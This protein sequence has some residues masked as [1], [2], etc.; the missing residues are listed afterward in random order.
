LVE[1]TQYSDGKIR[2]GWVSGDP[3]LIE[4]H[5]EEWGVPLY[6]DLKL[7]EFLMLEGA[8]AGLNWILVLKKREN[9]RKAFSGFDPKIVA[10][11]GE[12]EI[13]GLLE[14]PG[15]IRNRRKIEGA[16]G[17][18]R[19]FLD[20]QEEFGSFAEYC[21]EFVNG[22]PVVNRWKDVSQIPKGTPESDAFSKD[23]K[24]RGFKFTGPTIIYSFMQA[25]GMVNDHIEDCFRYCQLGGR[26]N[27]DLR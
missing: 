7:F 22:K 6:D 11:Y 23:L 10:T 8:Q 26:G 25:V 2:C 24:S 20:I 21:W 5:D 15:I 18:A 9:Y 12:M 14:N 1:N 3:L 17:N 16:V 4:Y 19:L 27:P 13:M